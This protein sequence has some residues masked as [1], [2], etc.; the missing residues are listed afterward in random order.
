MTDIDHENLPAGFDPDVH[1]A[2]AQMN[3]GP[4]RKGLYRTP[5]GRVRDV[6]YFPE[7]G[8]SQFAVNGT[9]EVTEVHPG[10]AHLVALARNSFSPEVTR[11]LEK[12]EWEEQL[13]TRQFPLPQVHW[14]FAEEALQRTPPHRLEEA[15]NLYDLVKDVSLPR[16]GGKLLTAGYLRSFPIAVSQPSAMGQSEAPAAKPR[17]ETWTGLNGTLTLEDGTTIPVRDGTLTINHKD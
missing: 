17:T 7:A 13:V 14:D 1:A 9:L 8:L 10:L 6:Y 3:H 4:L 16:L 12:A 2:L 5:S 11:R 15:M